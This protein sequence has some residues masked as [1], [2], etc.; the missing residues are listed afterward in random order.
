MPVLTPASSATIRIV[1]PAKPSR[2]ITLAAARQICSRLIGPIPSFG[3]ADPP[4]IPCRFVLAGSVGRARARRRPSPR[5]PDAIG[6]QSDLFAWLNLLR[7][8]PRA[9]IV[10]YRAI[11]LQNTTP[12]TGRQTPAVAD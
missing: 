8:P 5:D 10:A 2:A 9:P 4:S 7:P 12:S 3:T 1:V 6:C 11:D